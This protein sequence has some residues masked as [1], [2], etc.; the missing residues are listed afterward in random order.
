MTTL[1]WLLSGMIAACLSFR[2]WHPGLC[3][4]TIIRKA[5]LESQ[6]FSCSR[7][8]MIREAAV[9][10]SSAAVRHHKPHDMG[11]GRGS[12]LVVMLMRRTWRLQ[13]GSDAVYLYVHVRIRGPH[14]QGASSDM[15][16]WRHLANRSLTRVQKGGLFSY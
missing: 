2:A 8:H 15:T 14:G 16:T 6:L 4:G 7:V 12:F 13:S 1:Y 5:R 9:Q 10:S 3:H 11:S